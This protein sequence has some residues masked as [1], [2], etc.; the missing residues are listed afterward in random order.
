MFYLWL[1][2]AFF[3]MIF[4]DLLGVLLVQAEARNHGWLSGWLDTA[5]W[6]PGIICSSVTITILQSHSL[7][8]KGLVI[9]VVSAANLGGTKIGQVIGTKYI[10]DTHR[11]SIEKRIDLVE[12]AIQN[13]QHNK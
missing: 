2:V 11:L 10:K 12:Q 3:S 5:Q 4:T 8:H 9:L 7:F 6:I 1:L 13:H